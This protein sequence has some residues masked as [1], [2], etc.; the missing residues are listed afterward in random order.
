MYA[1]GLIN[2][3]TIAGISRKITGGKSVTREP[4]TVSDERNS[5][6]RYFRSCR[7]VFLE[8][9]L[10]VTDESGR[11]AMPNLTPL[12]F[13]VS[14]THVKEHV[15]QESCDNEEVMRAR[16]ATQQNYIFTITL[17]N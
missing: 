1:L 10:C 7:D 8:C 11:R 15:F 5:R 17:N 3:L 9:C 13:L 2:R 6:W 16:T 12:D 4:A 14:L